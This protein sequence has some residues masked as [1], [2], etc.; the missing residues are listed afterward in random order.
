M[1]FYYGTGFI[2]GILFICIFISIGIVFIFGGIVT[3]SLFLGIFGFLELSASAISIMEFIR[4][5]RIP[6]QKF[7]TCFDLKITSQG[8]YWSIF[9]VVGVR[10]ARKQIT[11]RLNFSFSGI[12][13]MAIAELTFLNG[14]RL[15]FRA[16]QGP[17][18]PTANL[19]KSDVGKGDVE[20]LIDKLK[21]I[22]LISQVNPEF[23]EYHKL[24]R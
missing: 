5:Y 22:C 18:S 1:K 6:P 15:L 8:R 12:D 14:D 2:S 16:G 9:D 17:L 3:R 4:W 23:V 7:T 20:E 21:S 19:G 11:K 10:Y 13:H 24:A